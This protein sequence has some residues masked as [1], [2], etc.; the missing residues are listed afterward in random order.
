MHGSPG[1]AAHG[2][3]M[4]R[5]PSSV[6][7]PSSPPT[8]VATCLAAATLKPCWTPLLTPSR[9]RCAQTPRQ[10][11]GFCTLLAF[12]HLWCFSLHPK[13]WCHRH[14]L[15][16]AAAASCSTACLLLPPPGLGDNAGR[17]GSNHFLQLTKVAASGVRPARPHGWRR[18]SGGGGAG[19]VV[20]PRGCTC[21]GWWDGCQSLRLPGL[22]PQTCTAA[23]SSQQPP[24][25][26]ASQPVQ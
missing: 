20:M 17:D 6:D 1:A 12:G 8:S 26:S 5:L 11:G 7:M 24:P 15:L 25:C 2:A 18:V 9:E 10:A 4:R 13:L 23:L 21:L 22:Q 14:P 19:G 3:C 16:L